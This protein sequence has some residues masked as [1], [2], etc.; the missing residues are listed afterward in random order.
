[1]RLYKLTG[2]N[3]QA[4]LETERWGPGQTHD[5]LGEDDVCGSGWLY[6][7]TDPLLAVLLSP[8]Y[9][10]FQCPK[11]WEAEGDGQVNSDFG[12]RIGVTRLTTIREIEPPKVTTDQ[13]V[14]FA[15]LC[16]LEVYTEP[17]FGVW[18]KGWLHDGDREM[19]RAG[20]VTIAARETAAR[21]ESR[22]SARAREGA[23]AAVRAE[24]EAWHAAAE[25]AAAAAGAA[26]WETAVAAGGA[27]WLAGKTPRRADAEEAAAAAAQLAA[28]AASWAAR[29]AAQQAACLAAYAVE[30]EAAEA[31]PP[32]V[33]TPAMVVAWAEKE[34]S[35]A[36]E[37]RAESSI[38]LVPL[39]R[40]AIDLTGG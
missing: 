22:A 7:Y 9:G 30:A 24:A 12:L 10:D 4:F 19:E 21:A 18:A 11:L 1:M 34:E 3:G 5:T 13:R 38:D 16:A 23:A 20:A 6:A 14:K 39:A 27:D 37:A 17:L 31:G 8:M 40:R 15:L 35:A 33:A 28:Q 36:K 26:S 25:A 2:Q 32:S 29:A